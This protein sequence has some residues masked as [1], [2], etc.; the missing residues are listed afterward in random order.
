L[1][2][3]ELLTLGGVKG[4]EEKLKTSFS[5]GLS[6]GNV[7]DLN[8]RKQTFGTNE[9]G[10]HNFIASVYSYIKFYSAFSCQSPNLQLG[11][12]FF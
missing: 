7:E 9:V 2:E 5:S 10:N 4:L 12:N 3:K 8:A 6:N 11:Y 1:N